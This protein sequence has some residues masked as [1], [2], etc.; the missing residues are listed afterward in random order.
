MQ[1]RN[2]KQVNNLS[3][4]EATILENIQLRRTFRIDTPATNNCTNAASFALSAASFAW[5]AVD[6]RKAAALAFAFALAGAWAG[7]GFSAITRVSTSAAASMRHATVIDEANG[8]AASSAR[9]SASH[10]VSCDCADCSCC[11]CC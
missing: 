6:L 7:A 3:Y 5:S 1:T 4:T 9:R 2:V 8:V 10:T 11:G